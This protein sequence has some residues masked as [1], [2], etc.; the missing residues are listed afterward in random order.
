MALRVSVTGVQLVTLRSLA[1]SHAEL[2][3]CAARLYDVVHD[4]FLSRHLVSLQLTDVRPLALG[5]AEARRDPL[6][7]ELVATPRTLDRFKYLA[8]RLLDEV[9]GVLLPLDGF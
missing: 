1:L 7:S 4:V 9:F 2:V 8:S 6:G 5:R 3:E